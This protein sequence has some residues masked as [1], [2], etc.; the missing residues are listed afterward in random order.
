MTTVTVIRDYIQQHGLKQRHIAARAGIAEKTLS[1]ILCGKRQL[2]ADEFIGLCRALN[3]DL[4]DF[5]DQQAS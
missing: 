1:L 5:I 4:V 3:L 2:R